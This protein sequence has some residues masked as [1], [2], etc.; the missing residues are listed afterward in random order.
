MA[1]DIPT[2]LRAPQGAPC[3]ASV[4]VW[5]LPLEGGRLVPEAELDLCDE[6]ERARARRF[7]GEIDRR[8]FLARRILRRQILARYAACAPQRLAFALRPTGKPCLAPPHDGLQFSQ[9]HSDGFSLLAVCSACEVGIDLE[10]LDP[11][12]DLEALVAS[13]PSLALTPLPRERSRRLLAFFRW[14][15]RQ[16][17]CLKTTGEGLTGLGKYAVPAAPDPLDRPVRVSHPRGTSLYLLDLPAPAGFVAA[18]AAESSVVPRLIRH[19]PGVAPRLSGD[20]DSFPTPPKADS[21]K[22]S[23]RRQPIA[24]AAES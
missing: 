10:R 14:W 5:Q 23:R 2:S 17:A 18:L 11:R 6:T 3:C 4:D 9:S 8:C 13:C 21:E 1:S 12:C 16:E 7:H 22:L 24:C 20:R 15:V 19:Q